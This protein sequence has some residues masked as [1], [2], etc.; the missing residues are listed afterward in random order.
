VTRMQ[1][2]GEPATTSLP[3]GTDATVLSR[4]GA[5][6]EPGHL[7]TIELEAE[8]RQEA[9]ELAAELLAEATS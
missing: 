3:A 7:P 4:L 1:L 5:R 2:P 8:S 9:R 6:V